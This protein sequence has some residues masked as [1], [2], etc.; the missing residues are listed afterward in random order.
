MDWS[1]SSSA[2]FAFPSNRLILWN[3]RALNYGALGETLGHEITHGF[4][5]EGRDYDK[6]GNEERW[7]SNDT[8]H[9]YDK[10]A[11]C[12]EELYS[13]FFVPEA[14]AFV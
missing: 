3:Y 12:L 13:S 5:N 6:D 8:I 2:F 10:R 4:D 14:N 11:K 7:W 9:E 1:K